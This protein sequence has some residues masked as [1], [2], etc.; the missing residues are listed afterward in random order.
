MKTEEYI[1]VPRHEY[2]NIVLLASILNGEDAIAETIRCID[3]PGDDMQK[4]V[5]LA[6]VTRFYANVKLL[7]EQIETLINHSN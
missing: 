4:S 5:A 6:A 1:R 7:T 3:C 2:D